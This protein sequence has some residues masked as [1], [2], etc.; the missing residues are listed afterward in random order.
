MA[1]S[2]RLVGLSR[3]SSTALSSL[4]VARRFTR[5]C[6][7]APRPPRSARVDSEAVHAHGTTVERNGR[8]RRAIQRDQ[9]S[10]SRRYDAADS[11]EQRRRMREFYSGWRARLAE[12]AFDKLAQEGR[13][14]YVL[15]DNHLTYQLALLDRQDKMRGETACCSHS[16]IAC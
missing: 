1:F 15:L 6:S 9:A 8:R 11:P 4:C 5:K 7:R 13:V 3:L 16:P 10:L 14:D 2:A 12:V